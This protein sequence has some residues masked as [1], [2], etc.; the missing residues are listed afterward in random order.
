[1]NENHTKINN[2][3]HTFENIEKTANILANDISI[4]LNEEVEELNIYSHEF[5]SG[6]NRN[7]LRILFSLYRQE[8][9]VVIYP[10]SIPG[11]T[12]L[13]LKKT[14]PLNKIKKIEAKRNAIEEI[15]EAKAMNLIMDKFFEKNNQ[16]VILIENE[17]ILFALFPLSNTRKNLKKMNL[18]VT[19]DN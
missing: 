18:Y 6:L 5:K 9:P 3:I 13:V 4:F 8:K 14:S 15:Q 1:M 7:L 19:I 12:L 10:D 16:K 11:F 2:R 17:D